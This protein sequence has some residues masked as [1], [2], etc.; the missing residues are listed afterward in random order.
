MILT[1][2]VTVRPRG[3]MIKYYREKGYDSKYNQPLVVKV[4]D[5][6]KASEVVVQVLCEMCKDKILSV[7]YVDYNRSVNNSGS[8]VCKAC[9]YA[10]C[11]QTNIARYGMLYTETDECKEK[12]KKTCIEKF[13]V[14]NPMQNKDISLKVRK[15]NINKY[16]CENVLQVSEFKSKAITTCVERYGIDNPSKSEE[17]KEKTRTTN[18]QRYGVPYTQQSPEVRA[19][20]NATLCKNGT[21]KTSKQQLYL[22]SILGGTINFPIKYYAVDICF[23]EEKLIIEYDGGGHD[24]RVTLGNLTQEEFDQREIVRNNVIKKEGYKRIN[25]VSKTDKLP[26]DEILLQ[27]LSEASQYF[28]DFPQHSWIEFNLNTSTM[29]NAEHKDGI[30]YNYGPLRAIKDTDLQVQQNTI[31]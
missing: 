31:T 19:K 28:S 9:S 12:T 8:Y 1:K 2:E 29:R 14:E 3:S 4:E 24:L 26:S 18:M 21:Q 7:R 10:K 23:P 17:I 13:G 6:P 11:K 25:I 5:L 30:P 27:M 16:G 22:Q 15:T 20:A